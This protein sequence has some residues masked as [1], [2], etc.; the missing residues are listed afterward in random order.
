MRARR[1]AIVALFVLVA[2][3]LS[4]GVAA[5][6]SG[7]DYQPREMD[8]SEFGEANN[9][10]GTEPGCHNFKLNVEDSSGH[11]YAQ[12]GILQEAQGENPH[13]GDY[14]VNT[15]SD[16]GGA[17][18]SGGFNSNWE[19]LTPESCGVFDIAT[20]PFDEILYLTGQSDHPPCSLTPSGQTPEPG[21]TPPSVS[22]G[23]PDG[24]IAGLAQ[25]AR[26]YLGADDNLDSGE[27]DGV[28]RDCTTG[29]YDGTCTSYPDTGSS[30][31]ANGPSD[32]GAITAN[33]HPAEVATWLATLAA[34]PGD[35]TPFLTN[36]VP[37]ADAGFGMC[38][39]NICAGVY[40]RQTTL[41]DGCTD[42]NFGNG[43]CKDNAEKRDVY[44]YSTKDWDPEECSSGNVNDE[45]KCDGGPGHPHTMDQYRRAEAQHVVAE[46]GVQVYGDPDPQSSPIGPYPLP[47]AYVGTCG[48]TVGGGQMDMSGTPVSNSAG[49]ASVSTGC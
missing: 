28:H 10:H 22:N 7:G 27:H 43:V 25:D 17:G 30:H 16:G 45:T 40:T 1:T 12:A 46:P 18:V 49:Q 44:D 8:C 26:L 48:V 32:G 34:N 5:A 37:V 36:P 3:T 41:Y 39:D 21:L 47:A 13:A 35:P 31:S 33:W 6:V 38:A 19:P 15:N 11:R 4:A 2:G 14:K 9:L 42:E 20:L 23:T 24:S 29:D